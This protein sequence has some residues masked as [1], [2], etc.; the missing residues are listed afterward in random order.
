MCRETCVGGRT[1]HSRGC[2]VVSAEGGG[3]SSCSCV[4]T[5]DQ[6]KAAL[7][8]AEAEAA[9]HRV[10]LAVLTSV[11]THVDGVRDPENP[12]TSFKL[13]KPT[14]RGTC[15]TDGHYVCD[16]CTERATCEGCG[17]RPSDCHC[18]GGQY[19]PDITDLFLIPGM[20]AVGCSRCGSSAVTQGLCYVCS[21]SET[22]V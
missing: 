22:V 21:N 8:S 18:P 7:A 10:R 13:G 17:F 4:D 19:G 9:N 1:E 3:S 5:I 16:D 2:H 6:V 12:C 14:D 11:G 15:L 20:R